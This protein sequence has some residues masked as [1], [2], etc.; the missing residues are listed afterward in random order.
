MTAR[1][2]TSDVAMTSEQRQRSVKLFY[3]FART[4]FEAERSDT[5]GFSHFSC[6][7]GLS[8][9]MNSASSRSFILTWSG[10]NLS[11]RRS[12]AQL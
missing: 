3:L 9:Q 5:L 1:R 6:G 7:F 4:E 10:L 8:F 11:L 2:S 12:A